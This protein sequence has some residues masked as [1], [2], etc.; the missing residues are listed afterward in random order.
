MEFS[1]SIISL[2]HLEGFKSESLKLNR[3]YI[4]VCYCFEPFFGKHEKSTI[5]KH[6][7]RLQLLC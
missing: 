4:F 3:V 5:P 1:F 7:K 2:A 6:L